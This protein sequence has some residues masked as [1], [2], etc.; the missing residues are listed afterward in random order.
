MTLVAGIDFGNTNCVISIPTKN[1][2]NVVL[3]Q[4][5]NRLTPTMVTF[6]QNENRRFAGE[7]SLQNQLGNV[8]ETF[9]D[10]KHLLMLP[11]NSEERKV[12]ESMVP[13]K[14]I[15]LED[16]NTGVL[17]RINN[18][19]ERLRP[20][21]LIAV[22]MKELAHI[23]TEKCET[24]DRFVFTVSP[25]WTEKH[26]R[27]FLE[28]TK[29]AG[30]NC[31]GLVNSTTAAAV[32]YVMI[33]QQ[34]LPDINEKPLDFAF[35]DFGSSSMNVAIISMKQRFV[36][37][38]SLAYN[39]NL[40]GFYFTLQ[41]R[42]F[43][44]KKVMEKYHIDPRSSPRAILR[45][46][47][48]VERVK[49]TLSSNP[50]VQF[51][52][53]SCLGVDINFPVHR[54]EFEGEIQNL[55]ALIEDPIEKALEIANVKKED[56]FEVQ[57]LG[58]ASRVPAVY[59]RLTEVFGCDPKKSLDL[60]ECFAFGSGYIAALLSPNM[61][62]Q[63]DVKDISPQSIFAK[64]VQSNNEENKIE[65]FKQFSLIPNQ[66]MITV[67]VNQS[68][69]VE[70]WNQEEKIAIINIQT[71]VNTEV[72]VN[73]PIKITPSGIIE[74][75]VSTFEYNDKTLEAQIST[76]FVGDIPQEKIQ[77]YINTEIKLSENDAIQ[78]QID[79][80]KNDL[81]SMILSISSDMNHDLVQYID[82][83][84]IN[85]F[86]EILSS[87]QLWYEENEF[88][89][90]PL[91]EYLNKLKQLK[92]EFDPIFQH[93]KTYNLMIEQL[94]RILNG[95][96]KVINKHNSDIY[97]NQSP[98]YASLHGEIMNFAHKLQDFIKQ[99]KYLPFEIDLDK[100][101][102][103]IDEFNKRVD[104]MKE[105]PVV[106]AIQEQEL[107]EED[108][109][110]KN[111]EKNP[112]IKVEYEEEEDQKQEDS[113]KSDDNDKVERVFVVDDDPISSFESSA[114]F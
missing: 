40:G 75:G 5:S 26:R 110:N 39:Q 37:V 32:S 78:N 41:L 66:K 77:E 53:P 80:T 48:Q 52:V 108:L 2:I 106:P 44:L 109:N 46:D 21:Q 7:L 72:K 31:L 36:H 57:I 88:E 38:K 45:F 6:S 15:Q 94:T 87:I 97:H 59:K 14:L 33:H 9:T 76:L 51:E 8:Q 24:V 96:E 28:A 29:I 113:N 84:S 20:E 89:R 56:L 3:N 30:I 55:I 103:Q 42:N 16:G 91:E 68:Q 12:I 63:L 92:D 4:S 74:V 85:E 27:A 49:K 93:K 62:I 81:E 67:P 19:E 47:Q 69:S 70:L 64:W 60:D 13:F 18:I 73:L 111:A 1:G 65:V 11:Y 23:T 86:K 17:A 104:E 34:R 99:P 105:S 95:F 22:L 107:K 102:S 61:I 25:W 54:E 58:G 101:N 79:N 83:N 50:V 71:S 43:L 114:V 10:L 82:P 90:L 100:V 35:V 112:N 98:G